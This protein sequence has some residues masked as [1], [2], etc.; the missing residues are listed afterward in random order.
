MDRQTTTAAAGLL[1]G[2]SV[3]AGVAA[4]LAKR[5]SKCSNYKVKAHAT[6]KYGSEWDEVVER[7]RFPLDHGPRHKDR[8][9]DSMYHMLS[10]VDN[11]TPLVRVPSHLIGL[12]EN[13]EVYIKC[14][15]LN[16]FGAVKDRVAASLILD[17]I[18]SG[19]MANIKSLV[20]P[21][22]GN[23]GLGLAMMNNVLQMHEKGEKRGLT[24]PISLKVPEEKRSALKFFG[25]NVIELQ[26]DL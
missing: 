18:D 17:A 22:S 11:P 7:T 8:V 15:W 25:A 9:Y 14:E 5:N 4:Y 1:I 3:G 2:A 21:T 16:P 12:S 13:A 23:T 10:D 20:E 26:D 19:R 6:G 24:V